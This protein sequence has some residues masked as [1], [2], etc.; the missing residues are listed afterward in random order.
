MVHINMTD[1]LSP[2]WLPRDNSG[3]IYDWMKAEISDRNKDWTY[4]YP[5][6]CFK[7]EEDKVKFILRWL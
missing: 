1:R 6:L 7:Y 4:S 2:G 3:A 5:W